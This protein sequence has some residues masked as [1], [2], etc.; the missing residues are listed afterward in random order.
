MAAH[1]FFAGGHGSGYLKETK[2][3]AGTTATPLGRL[4]QPE[5]MVGPV[6]FLASGD[7]RWVTGE[8]LFASGGS[9]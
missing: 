4:G 1:P 9:R 5:D 8:M 6:V 3:K 2:W 7:A